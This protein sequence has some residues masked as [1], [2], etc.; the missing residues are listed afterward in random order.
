MALDDP[1]QNGK[2]FYFMHE[3]SQVVVAGILA[4]AENF[5][6]ARWRANP[7]SS[8]VTL[9]LKMAAKTI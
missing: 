2:A 6:E 1:R 7:N 5:V 3:I 8:R 4:N 9:T